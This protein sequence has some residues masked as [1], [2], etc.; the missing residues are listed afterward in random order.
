[1]RGVLLSV[2]A[3]TALAG[4]GRADDGPLGP[5]EAVILLTYGQSLANGARSFHAISEDPRRARTILTVDEEGDLVA[6]APDDKERPAH[7]IAF[8]IAHEFE[9]S[10]RPVPTL[11][12]VEAPLNGA[13]LADL[14]TDP[15]NAFDSVEAGLAAT[16]EDELFYVRGE[17]PKIQYYSNQASRSRGRRTGKGAEPQFAV[18]VE[19]LEAAAAALEAA[20][21]TPGETIYMPFLQGQSD[22]KGW[23]GSARWSAVLSK[24]VDRTEEEASRIFGKPMKVQMFLAQTRGYVGDIVYEQLD[25]ILKDDRIHFAATEFQY[26]GEFPANRDVLTGRKVDSRDIT[27]LNSIGYNLIGQQIGQRIFTVMSGAA[28]ST[29][30]ILIEDVSVAGRKIVVRFAHVDGALVD[31]P[32]VFTPFTKVGPPDH[33]GFQIMP[34][35][36]EAPLTLSGAEITGPAEVT[37]TLAEP[38]AGP[39]RLLTGV[40]EGFNGSTL[41]DSRALSAAIYPDATLVDDIAIYAYVPRQW[42][43]IAPQWQVTTQADAAREA[44]PAQ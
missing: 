40:N 32:S 6:F 21:L 16:A 9:A 42:A 28:E 43:K 13:S 26:Q 41:R 25:A 44:A 3:A 18:L 29:L 34:E 4:C 7:A 27:H 17:D 11:V 10:G 24:L 39:A 35:G 33:F 37:L 31:D 36:G 5:G 23:L 14:A 38:L 1:M 30:P 20:E 19:R 12:S 15:A 2:A 8:R 22:D